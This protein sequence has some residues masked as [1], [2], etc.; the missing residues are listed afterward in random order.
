MLKTKGPSQQMPTR[1]E[2]WLWTL[3]AVIGFTLG[4]S[5]VWSI[6]APPP[7]ESGMMKMM[8]DIL[9]AIRTLAPVVTAIIAFLAL[10]NWQRQDKAKRE[11]EFLDAL[12]DAVHTY[13]AAMYDPIALLEFA[14]IGMAAHT[15]S[16]N[17]DDIT[18][19][20]AVAYIQKD[21]ER[22]AKRMMEAQ[23]AARPSMIRLKSLAAKGQVFSFNGYAKCR[24][25]IAMLTWQLD[26]LDAFTTVIGSPTW[27]WEHPKV[28]SNLKSMIAMDPEDL[29]KGLGDNNVAV[30]EF[31]SETY[32]RLYG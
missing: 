31:A 28:L 23:A 18:V 14:K 8:P 6:L 7:D 4:G 12:V 22:H 5:F 15:R 21:G 17:D 11:A 19:E 24:N 29:R 16:E 2:L 3:G 13:V 25:A 30:L 1:Q 20:G 10:R 32:R 27:N 9:D 26:K